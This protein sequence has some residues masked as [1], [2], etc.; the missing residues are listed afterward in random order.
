MYVYGE[1]PPLTD[2]LA[3]PLDPPLQLSLAVMEGVAVITVGCEMLTLAVEVQPLL[4]VTVT[5]YAPALN[6]VAVEFVPPVG[7]HA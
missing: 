3:L 2:T 4:S 6:P 5:V 1:V 7:D